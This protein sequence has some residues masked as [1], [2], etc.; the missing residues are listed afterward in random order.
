[1]TTD[2]DDDNG[3]SDNHAILSA[4]FNLSTNNQLLENEITLFHKWKK[5]CWKKM[6]CG[7]L[8]ASLL[9]GHDF[10]LIIHYSLLMHSRLCVNLFDWISIPIAFTWCDCDNPSE[11]TSAMLFLCV[12]IFFFQIAYF[13][14]IFSLNRST[15]SEDYDTIMHLFVSVLLSVQLL[16]VIIHFPFS[17]RQ[18]ILAS[19]LFGVQLKLWIRS[20]LLSQSQQQ[21]MQLSNAL[22][23]IF[24]QIV[25][26]HSFVVVVSVLF[27]YFTSIWFGIVSLQPY[28]LSPRYCK[29]NNFT[30]ALAWCITVPF[31]ARTPRCSFQIC[32]YIITHIRCKYFVQRSLLKM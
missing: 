6:P 19:T 3:S 31:V 32:I 11:Y 24:A 21:T 7:R 14:T 16:S 27:F 18:S 20:P 29:K 15:L 28:V 13:H 12:W 1:M 10:E 5:E 25:F 8:V 26:L 22:P 30:L 17:H 9:V 23:S 4:N 2:D